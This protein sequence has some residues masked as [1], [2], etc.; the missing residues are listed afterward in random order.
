VPKIKAVIDTN[1]FVS[2]LISSKGSPR[3]ILELAKKEVFKVATSVPINREILEVLHRDYIYFK[4]GLNEDIIDDIAIFLY[5]GTQL[6]NDTFKFSVIKKDPAD[7]KF[8]SCA[9]EVEAD[10]I[11]SGDEH[12]LNL[13][14][15]KGIQIVNAFSFLKILEKILKKK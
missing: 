10:Y 2:G 1:L 14:H 3:K 15:Y 7:N 11:I 9:I 12:L 6:T 13:K 5:E 4:Y 8:I